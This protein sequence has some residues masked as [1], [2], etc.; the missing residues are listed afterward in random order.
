MIRAC[1]AAVGLFFAI[2]CIFDERHSGRGSEVENEIGVYGALVDVYGK[3][4]AG[5]RVKAEAAAQGVGKRSAAA[6]D[7]VLTDGNGRYR[8]TGLARG[9]YDLY[10]DSKDGKL[11][12]LIPGISVPD[13]AEPRNVGTDTLRAPGGIRGHLSLAGKGVEGVLCYVPGTSYLAVSGDSGTCLLDGLPQGRYTVRF[14]LAGY[15]ITP[16]S[17]VLVVSGAITELPGRILAYD[18]AL[19]PP[20]PAALE[21]EFDTLQGI[22][23]LRWPSVA[24]ADRDGYVVYRKSP[25]DPKPMELPGGFTTDTAFVDSFLGPIAPDAVL[26]FAYSVKTRDNNSDVSATF[27]P[28]ASIRAVS[29]LRA[30][31]TLVWGHAAS[32]QDSLLIGDS[33]AL[34]LDFSNPTRKIVRIEWRRG[35]PAS[36]PVRTV[37][38]DLLS[39]EDTLT[40]KPD[41]TGESLWSVSVL[42]AAGTVWKASRKVTVPPESA[43]RPIALAKILAGEIFT[44]G[45]V[46]VSA[47]DSRDPIGRI[48]GYEYAW[49]GSAF[50]AMPGGGPDM[51]L[52]APEAPAENL[53]LRIRVTDDDGLSDTA[54]LVFPVRSGTGWKNLDSDFPAVDYSSVVEFQGRL[55]AFAL[56][57]APG[58]WNSEDGKTWT[59]VPA[60]GGFGRDAWGAVVHGGR[61]WLFGQGS[62]DGAL[63][64]T[65]G[66]GPWREEALPKELLRRSFFTVAA[67][68][69]RMWMFGGDDSSGAYGDAWSSQ[70]G[71]AWKLESGSIAPGARTTSR[72]AV[73]K[74]RL[75]LYGGL[76]SRNGMG[77]KFL[78]DLW[79]SEDGV[80]WKLEGESALPTER[81]VPGF[82]AFQ[83]GLWIVAGVDAAGGEHNDIW[84]TSNGKD[85]VRAPGSAPFS[86]RRAR[87]IIAFRDRM[88]LIGGW[89]A[90]SFNIG[91]VWSSP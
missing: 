15:T 65:D 88:H 80:D 21:A 71:K 37:H 61:I 5:A 27:S 34:R 39:G 55:W 62:G 11:V 10:G 73:W 74:D 13:P 45:P 12:V 82:I 81:W 48:A 72:M 79:S 87:S 38:P 2:S 76:R 52:T 1:L 66:A 3:P 60:L 20:A 33:L 78:N 63:L 32:I 70:D 91:E 85:W 17:G 54:S 46:S 53:E 4:M 51:T 35:D 28:P 58:A 31:T 23:R 41:S 19:P 42:D 75:W 18:T 29:G 26:E 90:A 22:V 14:S 44:L 57:A 50:A 40:W 77:L 7:S 83:D 8:F 16:D 69:G 43:N 64:S 47:R 68:K 86:P 6:G 36:V 56:G 30:A 89:N 25:G 67:F 9:E 24:V 84:R 49:G 59:P